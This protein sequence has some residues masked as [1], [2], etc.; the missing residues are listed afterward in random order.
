MRNLILP[1]KFCSPT[2]SKILR[3]WAKFSIKGDQNL[4]LMVTK[5]KF[6][7]VLLQSVITQHRVWWL[8]E[9][10]GDKLEKIFFDPQSKSILDFF[11]CGF[12][13]FGIENL[14]SEYLSLVLNFSKYV[15]V[16]FRISV[17]FYVGNRYRLQVI[18]AL[19]FF[20]LVNFRRLFM[21]I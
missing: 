10:T 15:W 5:S 13:S 1:P 2:C 9:R 20:L 4:K 17:Y 3:N 16:M 7:V 6:V 18:D 11:D 14:V 21:Y 8:R 12:Q 19:G